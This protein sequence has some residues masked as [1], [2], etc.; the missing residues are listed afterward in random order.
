M[1]VH[2]DPFYRIALVTD[3]TR[4]IWEM[5]DGST[6]RGLY[7]VR[8][9]AELPE[10][11]YGAPLRRLI[12]WHAR[13]GGAQLLHSAAVETGGKGLL[14]T[15][16]GGSGKST[17]T[18]AFAMAGARIIGEDFVLVDQ[19]VGPVVH[20]VFDTLKLTG[21]ALRLFPE[22]LARAANADRPQEKMRIH[23]TGREGLRFGG[24][25]RIEAI[26]AL[27]LRH[28]PGTLIAPLDKAAMVRALAPSTMFLLRAGMKETFECIA[29]LVNALPCYSV[30]L[31]TDP[32][33]AAAT[34][35]KFAQGLP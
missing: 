12:Q 13:E 8:S 15:G 24:P 3:E 34:I 23:L 16:P 7:W 14:L 25:A 26:C 19:A 30:A 28:A 9:A 27:R 2:W 32:M 6:R 29:P 18:A 17:T 35:S 1:R 4:G 21:S 33:E 31:G 5:Y 10:W 20:P 22:L 11:E